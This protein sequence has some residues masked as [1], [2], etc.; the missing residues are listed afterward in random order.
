MQS[1]MMPFTKWLKENGLGRIKGFELAREGKIVPVRVDGKVMITREE[2]ERF[3]KS[4]PGYTP[5]NAQA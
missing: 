1:N 2:A 3:T 4:L 5:T